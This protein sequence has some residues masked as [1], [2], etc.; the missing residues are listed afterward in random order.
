MIHWDGTLTAP[1][2][3]DYN[4]GMQ[5]NGFFRVSLDG[6]HVTMDFQASGADISSAVFTWRRAKPIR[7]PW[8]MVR[9]KTKKRLHKLVWSKVDLAPQT[10]SD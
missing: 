8:I 10:G 7:S 9:A 6:K 5:A 4:L 3:G 2:T 1:E